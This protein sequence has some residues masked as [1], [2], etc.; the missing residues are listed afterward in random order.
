MGKAAVLAAS[1]PV[2]D[3]VVRTGSGLDM[4][5][6]LARDLLAPDA[7][8]RGAT[9]LLR[10]IARVGLGLVAVQRD[11]VELAREAYGELAHHEGT[12]LPYVPV[13]CD[14]VLGLLGASTDE[15]ERAFE[16]FDAGLTF[17]RRAEY[18][19]EHAWTASDYAEALL[20]RGESADR[21]KAGSLQDEALAITRELGMT[22]LTER[23]LARREILKA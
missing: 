3:Q 14:R 12:V 15:L 10:L 18:Q 7:A 1:I 2:I 23:I 6:D 21:K 22:P 19:V 4:A 20:D 16:H 11:D 9:P 17:C 8:A 13:T 5:V